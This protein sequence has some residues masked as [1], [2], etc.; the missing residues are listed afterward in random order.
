VDRAIEPSR[1]PK[2]NARTIALAA[3]VVLVI[4]CILSFFVFRNGSKH[5]LQEP[6]PPYPYYSEDVTFANTVANV[7]LAGTLTLPSK[8]G[9]FPAVILISGSGPQTRDGEFAGHKQFLVLSDYLTRK[10]I[11]V[12]RFDDRGVG[13]STGNFQRGTSL[14]FSYDV[15]AAVKYLKTRT[16]IR[17]D[18]I[19]LIG[20][21]D[22]GMI[23]P[24]VAARS[25]EVNFIVLLAGPGVQCA[26]LLLDRQEIVERKIGLSENEIK[27]SRANSEKIMEIINHTDND[28]STR[29]A[30]LEFS[31][32]HQN[33]IPDD[34]VPSGLT[35]DQ[36]I[37]MQI[38]MFSSAWFK[39]LLAYD[40]ANTLRQVK[41]P[42]LALNGELDVQVP[43]TANLA[44]IDSAL[45]SGGNQLVTIVE[46]P[47]LNHA[48]QECKTGMPDE[49]AKIEQTFSPV[50]LNEINNWIVSVV[51]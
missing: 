21:S 5:R 15:E 45:R 41:C 33:E 7:S 42:V 24:M 16:E 18:K 2:K 29:S 34:V 39:Y 17:K 12:L 22:G 32:A 35:K 19:G 14:D 44:R 40:P 20:H 47:K 28:D 37:S 38:N 50:A 31:R 51:R 4:A 13:K 46:I 30:L 23:A 26:K 10:G 36:F 43:S 1:Q 25:A 48:F 27:K 49:Y 8:E 9:M 3:A 6:I 11:A